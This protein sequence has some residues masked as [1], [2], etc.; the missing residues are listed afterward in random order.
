MSPARN[1]ALV[2]A[3]T[4]AV[5]LTSAAAYL[6]HQRATSRSGP[7]IDA[8]IAETIADL[9]LRERSEDTAY[10]AVYVAR[11]ENPPTRATPW[12]WHIAFTCDECTQP[13][14]LGHTVHESSGW[15]C[16]RREARK[17]AHEAM[18]EA[19]AA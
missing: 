16:S 18:F 4:V 19:A 3:L 5:A 12:F 7:E 11:G 8:Y 6:A 13:E 9:T 17:H 10:A 1:R 14:D 2:R 15:A